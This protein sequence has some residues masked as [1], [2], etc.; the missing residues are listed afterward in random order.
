[1][2]RTRVTA[3]DVAR[4]AG[5]SQP[6]VSRVFQPG[7]RVSPDLAERVRAAAARIGYRPNTLARSLI[8]GR[9]RTIG[10]IVAALD[11]PFY[12]EAL[13][14]LSRALSR[15]GYHILVVM[16]DSH[17]EDVEGIVD[18]MMA[19]QVDGIV[20]ASVGMSSGLAARL[21]EEGV[22][23]VLFNRGQ[24]DP[25]LSSVTSANFDGAREVAR[26]LLA[27]GHD[28][29]AHVAGWQG[30]STGRDRQ[31]GFL[32][33]LAEAGVDCH[34]CVGGG[35]APEAAA[36]ATRALFEGGAGPD[37]IFVGNDHMAFAVLDTLR[38]ELG[39][40][41]PGDVSVVGYDDVAMAA[42]PSFRLTTVRQPLEEMVS[43]TVTHLLDQ[44]ERG[45]GE[46]ARIA[47]PGPLVIRE[48]ARVPDASAWPR[49]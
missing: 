49:G 5:V 39:L 28:R 12:T 17:G 9:S 30:A 8:T 20:L 46:V 21:A 33:G 29:P 38:L 37:A 13:E 23:L 11:N 42:W 48:T 14:T 26:F 7:G 41:V 34:A 10:L 36:E 15:R 44:V 4:L 47:L 19:H 45:T 27:G 16:T 1:M 2:R 32:A 40:R 43:A 3:Q 31:A 25:G 35:Y 24:D 6:S 22:P 18:D